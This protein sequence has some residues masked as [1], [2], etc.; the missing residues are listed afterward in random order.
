MLWYK[1]W[2]ETRFRLVFVL[3]LLTFL[4]TMWH[5][6]GQASARGQH[7]AVTALLGFSVPPMMMA[8]CAMLAGA[9]INTQS[10]LQATKGLHGS[11][12]YTLSLPV[13]RLRLLAVRACLGWLEMAATMAV[14]CCVMW[15]TSATVRAMVPPKEMLEYAATVLVCGSAL[16]FLSVLLGTVLDDVW[17]VWCTLLAGMALGWLSGQAV[18]PEFADLIRAVG[19]DSPAMTHAM[20]WEPMG[21]AAG[22]SAVLFFAAWKVAEAREY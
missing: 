19:R 14:F 3:G 8:V 13:S 20:P 11:T 7:S 15:W 1:G 18:L 12:L 10:A 5:S 4:L 6:R 9:G 22:M 17:R 16:Y 2:L 21:F